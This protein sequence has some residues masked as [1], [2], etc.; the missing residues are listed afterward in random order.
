M[1]GS[2]GSGKTFLYI[3]LHHILI[4]QRKAVV[5]VAWTG[6]AASLLP[7]G[8]TVSSTFKLNMQSGN[9]DCVQRQEAKEAIFLKEADVVIWNEISM[10]PKFSLEAV[11][12]A[13]QDLMCNAIL[14]GGKVVILGGDFRQA[15]SIIEHGSKGDMI[16]ACVK[17]SNH[18]E[19]FQ[20]HHLSV[21]MHAALSEPTWSK[22]L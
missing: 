10:V 2:G 8:R 4:G 7:E 13:L 21:N 20:M 15:L 16:A 1:D 17:N 3:F 22:F 6:V 9:H 14:F 11:D 5:C 19:K 12:L 18:R